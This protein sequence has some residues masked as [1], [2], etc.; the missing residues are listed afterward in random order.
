[1]LRISA[2]QMQS[3]YKKNLV[4]AR[5]PNNTTFRHGIMN[6]AVILWQEYVLSE[7][8]KTVQDTVLNVQCLSPE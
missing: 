8:F 2:E 4:L 3:F 7:V 5:R 1:M 6:L